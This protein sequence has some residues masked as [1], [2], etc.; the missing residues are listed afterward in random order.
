[1]EIAACQKKEPVQ[2]ELKGDRKQER[3]FA[4]H[5][6]ARCTLTR[7]TSKE[8]RDP[9]TQ[10]M[11]SRLMKIPAITANATHYHAGEGDGAPAYEDFKKGRG[12]LQEGEE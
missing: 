3:K 12:R 5:R 2:R 8:K 1:V 10:L 6:F 7:P 11:T 9:D 4:G